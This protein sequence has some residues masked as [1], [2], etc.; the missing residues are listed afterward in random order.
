MLQIL[1]LR[2]TMLSQRFKD[3][4]MI[5]SQT[6]EKQEARK[7]KLNF[8]DEQHKISNRRITMFGNHSKRRGKNTAG[9]H[10]YKSLALIFHYS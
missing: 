4:L 6:I 1:N 9:R 2:L 10:F 5:R 3:Y 7:S 8:I